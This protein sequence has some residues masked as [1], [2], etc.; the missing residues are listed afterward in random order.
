M[1]AEGVGQ[2]HMPMPYL[3]VS[4]VRTPPLPSLSRKA[5]WYK[6]PLRGR[7]RLISPMPQWLIYCF[8]PISPFPCSCPSL[9]RHPSLGFETYSYDIRIPDISTFIMYT[10]MDSEKRRTHTKIEPSPTGLFNPYTIQ[11]GFLCPVQIPFFEFFGP[12]VN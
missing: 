1:R 12:L 9:P 8:L 2:V 5:Y 6:R 7:G 3:S 10:Q 4:C 11:I